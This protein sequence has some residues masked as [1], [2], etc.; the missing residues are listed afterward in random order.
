MERTH[1]EG[2][3]MKLTAMKS[4]RN[5]MIKSWLVVAVLLLMCGGMACAADQPPAAADQ[6]AP[7]KQPKELLVVDL[8]GN[9][10]MEFVLV[11]P[12]TFMMGEEDNGIHKVTLTK[13]FY[14]G[15]Y[16]V[17][18]EQW[19]KVMGSNPSHF[20]GAKNPV[21]TV[22]WDDC[23]KFLAKLKE[24][25]HDH[26]F[27]LPTEAQWEYACRAGSAT[28]PEHLEEFG[29]GGGGDTTTYPVGGKKPNAWGLYDMHGN[30]WEWCADWY[31]RYSTAEQTDPTGPA[32]GRARVLRGGAWGAYRS[33]MRSASRMGGI[34]SSCDDGRG[35]RC[36]MVVGEA[37]GR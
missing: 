11:K 2:K 8:G 34:P 30:V 22:S 28:D 31:G 9:V 24:K 27:A 14:L 18:Q 7:D 29:W 5:L 15:K 20:K 25:A 19:E 12:G 26:Q 37:S 21:E 13:P 4:N 3:Y 23:Q 16:E 32:S 33:D 35:L 36:V 17:T 10:T 6:P 1:R